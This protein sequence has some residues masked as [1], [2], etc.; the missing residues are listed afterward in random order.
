M[1]YCAVGQSL[2]NGLRRGDVPVRWGGEEFLALLPGT[3]EVGLHATDERVRKLSENSW[4]H[5][6]VAVVDA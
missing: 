1:R 6:F 3:D 4:I 5:N 2:A